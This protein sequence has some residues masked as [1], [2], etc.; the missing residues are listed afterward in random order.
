LVGLLT[1]SS[2]ATAQT[3]PEQ[4]RSYTVL[5]QIQSGLAI[6]IGVPPAGS[7]GIPMQPC[8]TISFLIN[9]SMPAP[10]PQFPAGFGVSTTLV[11]ANGNILSGSQ[12]S[13]SATAAFP[14]PVDVEDYPS[15]NGT[16]DPSEL[17]TSLRLLAAPA[18]AT[19]PVHY[20][21]Q[22]LLTPRPGFN[23]GGLTYGT[24][25]TTF[26]GDLI[27]M[28]LPTA[29]VANHAQH[30]RLTLAPGQAVRL[31]GTLTNRHT[32]FTGLAVKLTNPAGQLVT[33][34][35]NKSVGPNTTIAYT[36]ASYSN[37]SSSAVSLD[38]VFSEQYFTKLHI[39][40]VQ[41]QVITLKLYLDQYGDPGTGA[42]TYVPGSDPSGVSLAVPPPCS[43]PQQ[44]LP[45]HQIT[46]IAAYVDDNGSVVVPPVDPTSQVSFQMQNVS[47][48]KG[49]AMN[50]NDNR[51]SQT[52]PDLTLASTSPVV[53][54]FGADNKARLTISV[55]DYGAWGE[56]VATHS[57][58]AAAPMRIPRDD[59]GNKVPD[60]GW[61]T[62]AGNVISDSGAPGAANED[63]DAGPSVSGPP[64]VGLVGDGL[65]QFEEYRGFVVKG[66][67]KRT[68]PT[69][70]DLFVSSNVVY[71]LDD[72]A[73]GFLSPSSALSTHRVHGPDEPGPMPVEYSCVSIASFCARLINFNYW[74][75]ASGQPP[76]TH[77]DQKAHRVWNAPGGIPSIVGA[78]DAPCGTTNG[79]TPNEVGLTAT[80]IFVGQHVAK[81]LLTMTDEQIGNEL[82]RTV[83]HEIAHALHVKHRN[84]VPSCEDGAII[85][86]G[87]SVMDS[88]WYFGPPDTDPRSQFNDADRAQMRLHLR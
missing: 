65:T 63:T 12:N 59:N 68:N 21:V 66:L 27:K 36:S 43:P 22:I 88:D 19:Y 82:R 81:G 78:T 54:S 53:I 57:W 87:P 28:S 69:V 83:A 58:A 44:C 72:I 8:E 20:S 41:V 13:M 46:A 50:L 74:N 73:L 71:K 3:C 30:F 49:M 2:V 37:P 62:A 26:G 79:S 34:L 24:A 17:V 23:R 7:G 15:L 10:N 75:Y 39:A 1:V 33:N 70:K 60:A 29:A 9:L 56:V 5:G 67:H 32:A 52:L 38:V 45:I 55:W 35:L 51:S 16:R 84:D 76:L 6:S 64:A 40:I 61:K 80:Q 47:A 85:G 31:S 14:R 86:P 18:T 25:P 77:F 4:S 42:G 11:G 48:F